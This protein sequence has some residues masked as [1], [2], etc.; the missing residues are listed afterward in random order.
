MKIS[1]TIVLS[2]RLNAACRT[3]L[4]GT[5]RRGNSILRTS[6]SRLT[7]LV[8]APPVDSLKNVNRTMPSSSPSA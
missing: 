2:A 3:T 5:A 7:R 1:T 6:D 8:T 4:S